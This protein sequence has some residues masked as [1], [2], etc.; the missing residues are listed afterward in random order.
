MSKVIHFEI[1]ADN[2]KRAAK[3]YEKVFGWKI[4]KWGAQEY[5]VIE[6]GPKKED[7]INGG[8]VAR[9]GLFKKKGGIGS[10][11]CTVQVKNLEEVAKKVRKAGGK[12]ADKGGLVHGVGFMQYFKDTEGNLFGALQPDTKAKVVPK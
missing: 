10:F 4:T 7:G 3:F 5:W 2:P 1:P 9:Q 11:V 12:W 6:G 8:L